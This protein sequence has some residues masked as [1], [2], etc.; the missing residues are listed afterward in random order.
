MLLRA[1]HE[2]GREG[3]GQGGETQ[4]EGGTFE[5]EGT[6]AQEEGQTG[7]GMSDGED[8]LFRARQRSLANRASVERGTILL[9]H[10]RQ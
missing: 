5:E 8:E 3:A 1:R 2:E 7:E 9:L 6:K 10:E 4:I